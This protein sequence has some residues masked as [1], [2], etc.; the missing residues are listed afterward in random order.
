MVGPGWDQSGVVSLCEVHAERARLAEQGILADDFE[1]GAHQLQD[2]SAFA[3]GLFAHPNS[4]GM[5]LSAGLMLALGRAT[6]RKDRNNWLALAV[7]GAALFWTFS[8]GAY[9]VVVVELG[10][11]FLLRSLRSHS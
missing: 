8:I 7:I 9:V 10:A 2:G 11:Y 4:L 6:E 5:F 1:P 3:V